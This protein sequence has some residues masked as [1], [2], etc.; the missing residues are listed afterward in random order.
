[1]GNDGESSGKKINIVLSNAE[2]TAKKLVSSPAFKSFKT[3]NE[4]LT[5]VE[6][7]KTSILMNL[8]T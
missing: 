5:A 6:K 8:P 3:F 1:M 4:Y 2:K 7:L